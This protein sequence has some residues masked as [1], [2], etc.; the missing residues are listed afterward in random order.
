MTFCKLHYSLKQKDDQEFADAELILAIWDGNVIAGTGHGRNVYRAIAY[1]L[2]NVSDQILKDY[3]E[4]FPKLPI[5]HN[6]E[7]FKIFK[8][9]KDD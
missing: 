9:S 1:A 8:E 3:P 5:D 2:R 6:T 4:T 7:L